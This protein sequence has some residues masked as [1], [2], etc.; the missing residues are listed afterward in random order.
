MGGGTPG[1]RRPR[2]P[3]RRFAKRSAAALVLACVLGVLAVGGTLAWLV[4]EDIKQNFFDIGEVE[5]DINEDFNDPYTVKK[6]VSV[7][8]RGSVPAYV[9][10]QVNIYWVDASGNQLWEAP[11]KGTDYTVAAPDIPADTGWAKGTDGLYYWKTPLK[12]GDTTK[13]LINEISQ[14][15]QRERYN[16]GRRLVVDIAV[17]SIQYEPASACMRLGASRSNTRA[18]IKLPSR[19]KRAKSSSAALPSRPVPRHLLQKG[20]SKP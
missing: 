12:P 14:E 1:G 3:K 4:K 18:P 16:D 19:P 11:V 15:D 13:N 5:V 20:R 9:R 10:A 6:N 8:N 7:T 17:Q 2:V